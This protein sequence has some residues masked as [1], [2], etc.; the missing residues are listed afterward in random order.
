MRDQSVAK[1][2]RLATVVQGAGHTHFSNF[3]VIRRTKRYG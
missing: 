1:R 2:F 3:T